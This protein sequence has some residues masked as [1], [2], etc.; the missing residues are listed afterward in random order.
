MKQITLRKILGS[1]QNM[2]YRV[3]IDPEIAAKARGSVE[4]ML[5]VGR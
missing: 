1:L 3:E 2:T 4:R 5:E